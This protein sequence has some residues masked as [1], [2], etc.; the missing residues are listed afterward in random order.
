M[1]D[2]DLIEGKFDIIERNL[3]FIRDNYSD[4]GPEDLENSYKDYQALKFSL[5]EMIEACID[6]ANHIISSERLRRAES[7]ADMFK[8]LGES[9][10]IPKDLAERLSLMARFRNLL[11]HRY[12]TLDSNRIV[13]IVR[14]HLTDIE[15][16]MEEIRRSYLME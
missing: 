11:I 8:V 4:I 13:E 9:K 12:E 16:F 7:Y 15:M 10:V 14:D 2:K 5:F 6:I 3:D 1:V